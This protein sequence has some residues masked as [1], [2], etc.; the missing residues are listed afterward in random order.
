MSVLGATLGSDGIG[1][2][3]PPGG[4]SA[5]TDHAREH[6]DGY[7]AGCADCLARRKDP[8]FAGYGPN[9]GGPAFFWQDETGRGGWEDGR[10]PM[11]CGQW[12]EVPD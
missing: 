1:P 10:P 6:C 7:V 5:H 4:L 8:P 9:T 12:Y 3:V 11:S 2:R